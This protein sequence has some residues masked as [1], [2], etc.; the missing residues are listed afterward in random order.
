MYC[1]NDS[2]RS[3]ECTKVVDVGERK[4]I[5]S[6]KRRCF[7][8]TGEKHRAS[9]CKSKIQCYKC[10]C[11]HHTSICDKAEPNPA[12]CQPNQSSVIYP[13]VVIEVE[14]IKC[15]A[16]LDTGSGNSYVSS[17]LMNLTKKKPARQEI[18]TI[19]MMLHTTTKKIDVYN[20]QITNVNKTFQMSS[21]V[22]CV[23]RPVLLTLPNPRYIEVIANNPH[24]E[25]VEMDDVDSKPMLPVHMILG[26][27]DY[28]R[29]KTT[30]PTKVG[31]DG[32][33]V[34]ENTR[35]GWIIMSQGRETNHSYLMLTKSTPEDYMELCSLDV[36]GL[37][38]DLK[39]IKQLCSRS[40]KNS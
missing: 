19:E 8:C 30:T 25:G 9:E 4:K 38:I 6:I 24:L 34:V 31:D 5:L 20:V 7:N 10:K 29:V 3:V 21:E 37:R 11:K 35:L 36:L 40:L 12:M 39:V 26:A 27:S 23:D 13:V 18:K 32:K 28:S 15:R 33:P 17:T 2:H 16:L 22:S 1:E 14:G